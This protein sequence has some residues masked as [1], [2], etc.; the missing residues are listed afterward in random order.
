[1]FWPHRF[2][3]LLCLYTNTRMRHLCCPVS[4]P[5]LSTA[6]SIRSRPFAASNTPHSSTSTVLVLNN[7]LVTHLRTRSLL[8]LIGRTQWHTELL[9]LC[10]SHKG[11]SL[12]WIFQ[13]QLNILRIFSLEC[14]TSLRVVCPFCVFT[15]VLPCLTLSLVVA[16]RL[17]FL[18]FNKAASVKEPRC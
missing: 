8:P 13:Q 4:A 11:T 1:M 17:L 5:S 18:P 10:L 12:L 14:K 16:G 15:I 3:L 7:W 2:L 6:W 9:Y